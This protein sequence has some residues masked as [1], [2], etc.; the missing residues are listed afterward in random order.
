MEEQKNALTG[1]TNLFVEKHEEETRPAEYATTNAVDHFAFSFVALQETSRKKGQVSELTTRERRSHSLAG[2]RCQNGR[3]W[4][5]EHREFST[6]SG[7]GGWGSVSVI[8]LVVAQN[9]QEYLFRN[10]NFFF[11]YKS[12][13]IECRFHRHNHMPTHPVI[14]FFKREPNSATGRFDSIA[15]IHEWSVLAFPFPSVIPSAR[16]GLKREREARAEAVALQEAVGKRALIS[17][18]RQLS[19]GRTVRDGGCSLLARDA[20]WLQ[21]FEFDVQLRQKS[22]AVDFSGS[23]RELA[24]ALLAPLNQFLEGSH[25]VVPLGV[26]LEHRTGQGATLAGETPWQCGLLCLRQ[27]SKQLDHVADVYFDFSLGNSVERQVYRTTTPFAQL[28]VET[29]QQRVRARCHEDGHLVVASATLATLQVKALVAIAAVDEERAT[30]TAQESPTPTESQDAL[31]PVSDMCDIVQHVLVPQ[32]E[33]SAP[34]VVLQ[35]LDRQ[36][37]DTARTQIRVLL[38]ELRVEGLQAAWQACFGGEVV[39]TVQPAGY[40]VLIEGARR[41]TLPIRP[42]VP[43]DQVTIDVDAAVTT[44]TGN[45]H[46]TVSPILIRGGHMEIAHD[47]SLPLRYLIRAR[48]NDSVVLCDP[49][50]LE[51]HGLSVPAAVMCDTLQLQAVCKGASAVHSPTHVVA[52][53]GNILSHFR[54][55][56]LPSASDMAYSIGGA[57]VETVTACMPLLKSTSLLNASEEL[58]VTLEYHAPAQQQCAGQHVRV[59][60]PIIADGAVVNT[61]IIDTT[62]GHINANA[63][64]PIGDAALSIRVEERSDMSLLQ[65]EHPREA[66]QTRLFHLT[67]GSDTRYT[68]TLSWRVTVDSAVVQEDTMDVT[69][70]GP[71]EHTVEYTQRRRFLHSNDNESA[72]TIEAVFESPALQRVTAHQHSV[73]RWPRL[74]QRSVVAAVDSTGRS[75]CSQ[76]QPLLDTALQRCVPCPS[77]AVCPLVGVSLVLPLP[78]CWSAA[79][80]VAPMPYLTSFIR[81]YELL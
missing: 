25:L 65:Q 27:L 78:G 23:R 19:G 24:A 29:V 72:V 71:I 42:S 77:C 46:W 52:V 43:I 31:F 51:E 79:D 8:E 48:C 33:A 21:R 74:R 70:T 68:G 22:A 16:K 76:R 39:G 63:V 69:L 26:H 36:R 44:T 17:S 57:R 64:L 49:C 41:M 15:D 47:V 30:W 66:Q 75:G 5:H 81:E 11:S 34:T 32:E 7:S 50:T 14:G 13:T 35:L 61:W 12:T 9:L 80:D 59:H 6:D 18:P 3:C 28:S 54:S 4:D 38:M 56:L 55:Q 53:T 1:N 73:I 20:S 45:M 40:G 67:L 2:L 37:V 58:H 60:V 62:W 10:Q